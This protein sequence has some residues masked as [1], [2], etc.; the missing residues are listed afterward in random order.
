MRLFQANRKVWARPSLNTVYVSCVCIQERLIQM[1]DV[2]KK[3]KMVRE[4]KDCLII[5]IQRTC[6]H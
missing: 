1:E 6:L 3:S 5:K 2:H 4:W